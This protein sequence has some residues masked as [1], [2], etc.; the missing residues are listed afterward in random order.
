MVSGAPVGGGQ[1]TVRMGLGEQL[2]DEFLGDVIVALSELHV[3]DGAVGVDQVVGGPIAVA[4]VGPGGV[5]VVQRDGVGD[6]QI[7][8][9]ARDVG[10]NP[11]EGV[12][13]GCGHR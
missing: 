10:R 3:P 5:T 6:A 11:F 7:A 8:G 1:G 12:L 9:P 2:S 4:V 13:R